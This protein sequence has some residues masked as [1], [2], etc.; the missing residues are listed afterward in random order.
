MG[1]GYTYVALE[2]FGKISMYDCQNWL[3]TLVRIIFEC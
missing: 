1:L 3:S 2:P